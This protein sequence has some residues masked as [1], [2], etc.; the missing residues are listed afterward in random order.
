MN[1]EE[2]LRC[3]FIQF[4]LFLAFLSDG[5]TLRSGNEHV[6]ILLINRDETF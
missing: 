5:R 2:I 3:R 1:F 4:T 6:S